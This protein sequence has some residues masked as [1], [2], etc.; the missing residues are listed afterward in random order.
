MSEERKK[1]EVAGKEE[2][3]AIH[4]DKAFEKMI[5]QAKRAGPEPPTPEPEKK[6]SNQGEKGQ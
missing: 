5:V 2:K 4:F 3:D 1:K 6:K